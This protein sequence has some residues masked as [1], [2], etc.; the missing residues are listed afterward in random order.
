MQ[1]QYTFMAW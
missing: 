1:N